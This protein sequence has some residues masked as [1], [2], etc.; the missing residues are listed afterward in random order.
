MLKK[1]F[2]IGIAGL[3]NVGRGVVKIIQ[4][5]G[6]LIAARAGRP[7]EIV[8][9]S[10]RD[11]KVDRGVGLT[12][13]RWENDP[14]ALAAAGDIDLVVELIGGSDG[15]AYELCRRSLQA[16][17]HFVTANKAMIAHH[18][19]ALAG[20][21]EA[22]GVALKFEAA[23][24]G[25]IPIIKTL[26]EGLSANRLTRVS[27]ILN[28][29]CNFI[30]TQMEATGQGFDEILAEAQ[31]LGYA[32]ADPSFDVDG[33]DTAH[34][35]AI[36]SGVAFGT[37]LDFNAVAI[38]GIR[39]I[40][41]VDIKYAGEFGYRIKLLGT[42]V[43]SEQGLEQRVAPCLVDLKSAIASVGGAF[44]A[45][46]VE[47]DFVDRIVIEGRGAGEGPTAS[48][49]VADII[50]IVRGGVSSV[51][52][53]PVGKMVSAHP[54]S[55]LE[56]FGAFYVRLRVQDEPGVMAEITDLLR[57][58]EISIESLIQRGQGPG[59]GI[60]VVLTT[61]ETKEAGLRHALKK[62]ENLNCMLDKPAAIRIE[63]L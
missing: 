39:N 47:G 23:V 21:A 33:V 63:K 6:A 17:K 61:H 16:G 53:M 1:P 60:F 12:A 58:Q 28:G 50:D 11:A 4:K 48:A 43:L 30:L 25:G 15:V 44:N 19:M 31:R 37:A 35:L 24:A 3:G 38:E 42:A 52:S 20:L 5:N 59:G 40:T 26:R 55:N 14:L 34:K 8:A 9:V 51:F 49:V 27:G 57:Q 2:K 46:A 10:A 32:E 18:G 62:M 36:L 29:T 7:V 41:A 13:Y 22:G 45:V 56:H 54:I